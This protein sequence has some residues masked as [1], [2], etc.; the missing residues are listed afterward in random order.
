MCSA[1]A[2]PS[3]VVLRTL[4]V[5]VTFYAHSPVRFV[6]FLNPT[7]ERVWNLVEQTVCLCVGFDS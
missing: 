5:T 7:Q 3:S 6:W 4:C 1:S 2:E